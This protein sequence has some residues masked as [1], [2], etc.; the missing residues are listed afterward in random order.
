M[1]PQ[2]R[3]EFG[4]LYAIFVILAEATIATEPCETTFHDPR[5]AH[6][7]ESTLATFH[8][9]QL[10]AILAHEFTSPLSAFVTTI[11][12]NRTDAWKQRT[13]TSQ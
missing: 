12:N 4:R 8:N 7:L 9:L 2:Y 3:S 6:D 10:P 13:Q 11:R 1:W 5:E